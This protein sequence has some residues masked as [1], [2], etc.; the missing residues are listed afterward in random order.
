MLILLRRK[1]LEFPECPEGHQYI[2]A[3]VLNLFCLLLTCAFGLF[4][5]GVAGMWDVRSRRYCF[6]GPCN[7]WPC[8]RSV[9][10]SAGMV[11]SFET[12]IH[13]TFMFTFINLLLCLT[14]G[15][16]APAAWVIPAGRSCLIGREL[17]ALPR[18]VVRVVTEGLNNTLGDLHLQ[19]VAAAFINFCGFSD[20]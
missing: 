18:A 10:S 13:V 6:R 3:P 9:Q 15:P 12:L 8:E 19:M 7:S 14:S 16:A 5:V 1:I 2:E 11:R 20:V 17:E 4:L